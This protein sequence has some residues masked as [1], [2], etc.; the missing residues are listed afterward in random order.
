MVTAAVAIAKDRKGAYRKLKVATNSKLLPISASL[1]EIVIVVDEGGEVLSPSARGIVGK[2]REGLEEIQRIARNEAVNLV[3][4]SLRATSD[5]ISVNI[6]KQSGL[7]VGMYVQDQEE[8]AFLFGWVKGLSTDDLPTKGCG[9]VQ[10]DQGTPRPFKARFLGPQQI[11][12]AARVISERR[13]ELDQASQDAAGQAYQG[14]YDRMRAAFTGDLDDQDQELN[15]P[16]VH[17]GVP[18]QFGGRPAMPAGWPGPAPARPRLTVMSGGAESWGDP[19]DL[20]P[21]RTRPV[22]VATAEAWP[23][24]DGTTT[25]RPPAPVRPAAP[26]VVPRVL[27]LLAGLFTERGAD[28]LWT[29]EVI[30]PALQAHDPDLTARR[31]AMMLHACGVEPARQAW[32]ED[33]QRG[34]GYLRADVD[35]AIAR[36]RAGQITPAQMYG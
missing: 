22:I 23:E 24:P 26:V 32:T 27:L 19:A 15:A 4:S 2:I 25:A 35:Q 14:R 1:P 31:L 18:A 3:V 5:M 9:F 21:R 20:A 12:D 6:R 29:T 33:G 34:R 36:I 28:R 10:H 17:H 8:L 30:L 16:V 11:V 7:R 13:P